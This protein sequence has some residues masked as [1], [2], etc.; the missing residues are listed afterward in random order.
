MIIQFWIPYAYL[1]LSVE[2]RAKGSSDFLKEVLNI[3]GFES[4]FL[5]SKKLQVFP[6]TE[7]SICSSVGSTDSG[8]ANYQLTRRGTCLIA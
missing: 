5:P 1:N 3:L 2:L 8:L 7:P 4:L 6:L